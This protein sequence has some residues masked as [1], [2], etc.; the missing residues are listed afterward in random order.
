[1]VQAVKGIGKAGDVFAAIRCWEDLG[2]ENCDAKHSIVFTN[3]HRRI[4]FWT[5]DMAEQHD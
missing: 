3:M 2:Y 1:M 4:C 5:G